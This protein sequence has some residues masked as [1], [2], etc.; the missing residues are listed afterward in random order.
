MADSW[1]QVVSDAMSVKTSETRKRSRGASNTAN[2]SRV[3][4]GVEAHPY[5]VKAARKRGISIS[6]YIRR[7][8]AAMAAL[9]LGID[10][11]EIFEKDVAITPIG[12]IGALPSKDLD[13]TLYGT[14]EVV[15]AE[16]EPD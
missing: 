10:P 1:R 7:A 5:I 6:G 9:D 13:G 15:H 12:R 4:F 2:V 14:W 16:A 11:V 8:T 3:G